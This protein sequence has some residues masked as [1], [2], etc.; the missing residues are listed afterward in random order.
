MTTTPR[1]DRLLPPGTVTFLFTDIEGSTRL[2][3]TQRAAMQQALAHH[4][5]ILRDAIEANDGYLVK[6]TGD[7][8]HAAFAIAADAIAACLAAQRALKAH[9]W[10]ELR[11][12][13]RMALHS[14]AAEQRGGDYYG[15]G[16]NRA[17]RLMA[18]AHGGQILLSRAT[19]ELV[20]D[21]LPADIALRDMGERRFK[22]LVRPE[23]VYQ[24]IAPG[25]P[26]DF[27]PLKTLDARPNNLPAQT[28]LFIGRDNEIRAVKERLSNANVRLLTLSGVGGTGKTRLALQAAADMVDEFEHGVFFVPLAALSDPALVLQTIAQAFDVREAAGRSLQEQLQGY[29]REKQ[30]LLVLD[31]FEQVIDA[32]PRV[33]DLLTAAPRLKVLVT[34]REV[35]R[36]SPETDH[37]VPPLSLPDP[38]R[39]PPLERLTQYEAVAFFIE[40]AVAVKPAFALTNENAPAVTEICHRL[41]GLPLAIELAA[42]RVRALPPQRMLAELSHRLSFLSGGARDLPARQKTLRGAIDWSYDLLTGDEQKLFRRLAVFVGGCALEAIESVCNLEN[43]LHVLETVEFARRQESVEAGRGRWR[44]ALCDAGNDPRVRRRKIDCRRR[45][46]TRA[47]TA[48]GLLPGA[49]GGGGTETEGCGAGRVASTF[50]RGARQF[51]V[52]SGVEPRGGGIGWR[53]PPLRRAARVLDYPGTSR[54]GPGVV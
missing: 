36:L 12:K 40:R 24:V 45:G 2:W 8:A 4:D 6:T 28:T 27:P 30:M 49:G 15:P 47:R 21:H 42:A 26:A 52:G 46:G 31:N 50:G 14:G 16:L 25:L 11:I 32:A 33:S 48:S 53:T 18:A 10:G 44:A 43:D 29:L 38:K 9:A 54:G 5:A 51:A 13:S 23:R 1:A 35:L 41:D 37:P 34:S 20:R 7:G 3:E 19:E 22:D 39:L 17:A